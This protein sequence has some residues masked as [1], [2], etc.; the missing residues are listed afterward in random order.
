VYIAGPS[1]IFKLDAAGMLTRI[2]GNGHNG[3]SGDGGPAID[4]L[5]GFPRAV[6]NDIADFW[7]VV[8]S[9]ATDRYDNLYIADFF[10]NRV[11]KITTDGVISTVAGGEFLNPFGWPGGV[12]VDT[13]G[14]YA[15]GSFDTVWRVTSD[16]VFP[17][18][19]NNCGRPLQPG[20]CVPYGLATDG[21]GNVYVADGGNCRVLHISP[22]GVAVVAGRPWPDWC[23]YSDDGSAATAKLAGP[24]SIALDQLGNIYIDDTYTHR[25][26]KIFPDGTIVTVVGKSRSAPNSFRGSY[27][28]DG[29]PAVEAELNTPHAVAVDPAGNIYIADTENF[30]VRK[31]TTDGVIT[32]VAGNGTWCCSSP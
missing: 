26:R 3:Y 19:G 29:G 1:I 25:I 5:L 10:N 24:Y 2:A 13:E 28:G 30:R 16:G 22:E 12:A 6:P 17:L 4:A 7:D 31:V 14:V 32:T 18:T 20:V 11:R 9:L 21:N 15:T 23:G 27:S 8:G